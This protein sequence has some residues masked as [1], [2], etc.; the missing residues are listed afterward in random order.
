M[1]RFGE[2]LENVQMNPAMNRY[3]AFACNSKSESIWADHIAYLSDEDCQKNA[4]ET[5]AHDYVLP[6]P[7]PRSRLVTGTIRLVQVRN[8]RNQWIFS[9]GVREH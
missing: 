4:L 1:I 5:D 7:F 6:S 9:I 8:V 3:F 2:L